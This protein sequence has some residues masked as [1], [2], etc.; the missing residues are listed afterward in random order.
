[1]EENRFE[2]FTLLIDGIHKSIHKIKIDEAPR[3]GVKGVHVFWLFELYLHP[4]GLTATEIANVSRIDRSL[5][6]REIEALKSDG[7]I[8]VAEAAKPRKYNE[9]LQLTE[10][11]TLVAENIMQRVF[12][13][14]DAVSVGI[15]EEELEIFYSV[16][17]RLYENFNKITEQSDVT[18]KE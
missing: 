10:K 9:R 1:M 13:I 14:Q 16:L 11:G 8:T 4:N 2:K 7:Y 3:L 6:S 12:C 18:I 5:V 17:E 15:D